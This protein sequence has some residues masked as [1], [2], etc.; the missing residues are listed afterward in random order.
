MFVWRRP[1][2][3][4]HRPR[5]FSPP[6]L[7]AALTPAPGSPYICDLSRQSRTKAVMGCSTSLRG[8]GRG[9]KGESKNEFGEIHRAGARLHSERAIAGAARGPSAVH[10]R[11]YPES[12]AR[13]RGGPRRRPD[14]QGGRALARRAGAGR[15]RAGQAAEGAGL[16]RGAAL[17]RADDGA[18]VRQRREDRGEGGRFLRHRRAA[19]GRARAGEGRR[20]GQ[21]SR[22]RR[23]HA[24][25]AERRDQR[26]A[27]GPHGRFG[28][29]RE[30]L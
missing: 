8:V 22:Q 10:A 6:A 9:Q 5:I 21:D 20:G 15:T 12:A 16:G 13:R 18:A 30:R 4:G 14:R 11:A 24:A 3:A 17:S 29:R 25:D 19:A 1:A 2:P 27:Q 7:A 28:E 26:S 23:R